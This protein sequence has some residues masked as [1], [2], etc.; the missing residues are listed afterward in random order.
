[1]C[2]EGQRLSDQT[3]TSRCQNC[4]F[5]RMSRSTPT[6][7]DVTEPFGPWT[8]Y[9][10]Y[11][12]LARSLTHPGKPP[13]LTGVETFL[14]RVSRKQHWNCQLMDGLITDEPAC[15]ICSLARPRHS[16]LI[17]NVRGT[18]GVAWRVGW[19]TQ[20]TPV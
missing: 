2:L 19:S 8:T 10:M 17:I 11:L 3:S 20:P 9:T 1:M 15:T 12:A 5:T 18:F 16:T 14:L 6:C 13:L 4:L 7:I